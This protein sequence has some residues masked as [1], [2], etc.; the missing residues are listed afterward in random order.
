MRSHRPPS[1]KMTSHSPQYCRPPGQAT[2]FD[3]AV[4]ARQGRS[5]KGAGE[6][7]GGKAFTKATESS[8]GCAYVRACV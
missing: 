2:S 6:R 1:P 7:E 3:S 5:L 4:Y 8:G